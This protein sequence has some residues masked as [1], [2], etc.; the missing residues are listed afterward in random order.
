MKYRFPYLT[1][2]DL[3]RRSQQNEGFLNTAFD[4]DL[5]VSDAH[6]L[7]EIDSSPEISADEISSNLKIE[8]STLSRALSRLSDMEF[9]SAR[10][11][12]TDRRKKS[13][14]LTKKGARALQ[15]FDATQL[16]RIKILANR[17]TA[18]EQ[19]L[20]QD[21]YSQVADSW[22]AA[23]TSR[24]AQEHSMM[25]EI[26]RITCGG[27]WLGRSFLK[28]PYSAIQWQILSEIRDASG[29]ATPSLLT[30]R[31]AIGGSNLSSYLSRLEREKLISRQR[32]SWD[33]RAVVLNLESAGMQALVTIEKTAETQFKKALKGY[34]KS[35]LMSILEVK[36]KFI[37]ARLTAKGE[38]INKLWRAEELSTEQE[39]QEARGFAIE[40]LVKQNQ[41]YNSPA[42]LFGGSLRSF[43][44]YNDSKLCAVAEAGDSGA[45]LEL[46]FFIYDPEA[47]EDKNSPDILELMVHEVE[48]LFDG[49]TIAIP[50]SPA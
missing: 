23:S 31:L 3:I 34:S 26:R 25:P 21:L 32:A 8:Q 42:I 49:E 48:D 12:K 50:D 17:I 29:R 41:H 13:L 44:L 39:L 33:R 37:G 45:N 5:S 14:S 10:L 2:L 22:N 15:K 1:L 43:A 16:E 30:R 11:S 40:Q 46:C 47:I 38:L 7:I 9:I 4:L 20:L 27:G 18:Y 24:R 6:I 36:A 28:T 35:E 19:S